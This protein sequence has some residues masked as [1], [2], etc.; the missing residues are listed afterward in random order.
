[1]FKESPSVG[2]NLFLWDLHRAVVE[3]PQ[4]CWHGWSR[5]LVLQLDEVDVCSSASKM[6]WNLFLC[7]S[8][9]LLPTRQYSVH[10][11][12]YL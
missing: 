2:N 5:L 6:V 12:T 8:W 11:L 1:M 9:D 4:P 10:W 7:L 3:E